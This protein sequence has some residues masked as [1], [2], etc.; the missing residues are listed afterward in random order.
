M[1]YFV[2]KPIE[3]KSLLSFT[4]LL[5]AN[6]VFALQSTVATPMPAEETRPTSYWW[7]VIGVILAIAAGMLLYLLIKKDPRKDAN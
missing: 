6:T 5:F 4:F 3:M 1:F 7:W 2:D